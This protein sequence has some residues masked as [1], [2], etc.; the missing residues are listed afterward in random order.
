VLALLFLIFAMMHMAPMAQCV[1][2]NGAAHANGCKACAAT[3]V[4]PPVF[5]SALH[6]GSDNFIRPGLRLVPLSRRVPSPRHAL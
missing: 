2:V 5:S 3:Q 6:F 1:M 4:M